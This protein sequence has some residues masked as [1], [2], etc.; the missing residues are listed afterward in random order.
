MKTKRK[1]QTAEIRGIF[2]RGKIFW[3]SCVE[4]G[5]HIQKSLRTSDYVE[6]VVRAREIKNDP[7]VALSDPLGA[8]IDDFIKLKLDRNE[9]SPASAESKRHCLRLF[10]ETI[11]NTAVANVTKADCQRFYDSY[12]GRVADS[13]RESYVMTL[14]SFFTT[15]LQQ[16]KV[17][18]N[19]TAGVTMAR[20]DRKG[21]T[22]FCTPEEVRKLIENAPDDS[23][24]F[25][26]FCGFY[27]GMRK[28]EIVQAKPSWFDLKRKIISITHTDEERTKWAKSR[29][30]PLAMQFIE[31]LKQYGLRAPFMLRP[32]IEKGDWRY[33]YD[34]RKPFEKYMAAM[35][36]EHVTPHVMRHT[37]ASLHASA[38]TSIFKIAEWMGDDVR[39]VQRNYAKLAPD[40]GDIERAWRD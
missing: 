37:F 18:E 10:A 6:A 17:R 25:I 12:R 11:G 16:K 22:V 5:K 13:T 26:L 40:N 15:L 35:N 30:V 21:R 38:G 36:C 23:M 39:V 9:W 19:P 24:R 28:Q 29:T 8:E 4:N 20:V 1:S 31:F 14:R 34:F 7:I 33:R 32:D 3:L 2:K 27:A